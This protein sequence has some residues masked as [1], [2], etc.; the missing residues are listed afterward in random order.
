MAANKSFARKMKLAKAQKMNKNIP[1]W[2]LLS[3]SAPKNR[4]NYKRHNWRRSTLK[5]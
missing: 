2:V 4:W 1:R 3:K 5:I